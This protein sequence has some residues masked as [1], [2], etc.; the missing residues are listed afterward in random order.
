MPADIA[1]RCLCVGTG[2]RWANA[3]SVASEHG[4]IDDVACRFGAACE[5]DGNCGIYCFV[6]TICQHMSRP[7]LM[8]ADH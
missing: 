3:D 4:D 6:V 8:R 1:G 2:L 5:Q 7:I